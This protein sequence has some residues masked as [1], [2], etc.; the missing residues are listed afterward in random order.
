M[1]IQNKVVVV[2]GGGNGIGRQ[3]SLALLERG[4]RVA[5]VDINAEALGETTRLAAG[6][7]EGL[8]THRADI[9]DPEA[10]R[11]LP[12]EITAKHGR[13]DILINNAGI[14][15]PFVPFAEMDYKTIQRVINI[16]LYG[17]M[18]MIRALLP[19]LAR[20]EESGIVNVSSMGGIVPVPGQSLYGAS[21]AALKLLS[22]SLRSELADSGINVSVVI[23]G[24]VG[25]NITKNSGVT[26]GVPADTG[27]SNYKVTTPEEAAKIILRGMEKGKPRILVGKDARFMDFMSRLA[28][29]KAGKMIKKMMTS[30]LGELFK[31]FDPAKT[32]A[33]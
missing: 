11:S 31:D 5:A 12:D 25:T 15:Q 21:K 32:K 27:G 22:E 30:I 18:L 26:Q 28:P 1:Q 13:I 2:T 23:P 14:I 24:G 16:N 8:S 19:H 10:V 33:F 17:P 4:A 7:A 20:Q 3:L 6:R 29:V 9:T